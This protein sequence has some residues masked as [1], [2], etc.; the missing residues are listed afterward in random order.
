[1]VSQLHAARPPAALLAANNLRLSFA[2]KPKQQLMH[3]HVDW[4]NTAK[5]SDHH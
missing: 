4:V 5:E 3:A 2:L 1:V